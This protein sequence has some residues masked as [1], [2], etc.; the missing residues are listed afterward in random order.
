M[1]VSA[2]TPNIIKP[3]LQ[4]SLCW[5]DCHSAQKVLDVVCQIIASEYVVTAKEHPELFSTK[6]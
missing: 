5:K 3:S 6:E 2:I 4:I 1:P